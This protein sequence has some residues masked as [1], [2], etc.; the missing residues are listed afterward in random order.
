[1]TVPLGD[2]AA[3]IQCHGA[4]RRADGHRAKRH[5]NSNGEKSLSHRILLNSTQTNPGEPIVAT[6]E[7][8]CCLLTSTNGADITNG[9]DMLHFSNGRRAALNKF[10]LNSR[11]IWQRYVSEIS[12]RARRTR[13]LFNRTT[14]DY[15][16]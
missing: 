12:R 8:I 7:R 15:Q 4:G 11:S 10:E 9:A 13:R 14:S 16:L 2:A 5:S 1:M 6:C 3:L